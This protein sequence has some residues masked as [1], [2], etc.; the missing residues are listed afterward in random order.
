MYCLE[1]GSATVEA[2]KC[3]E[4]RGRKSG[5]KRSYHSLND[6]WAWYDTVFEYWLQDAV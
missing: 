2:G 4:N 6:E 3:R 1:L 5:N